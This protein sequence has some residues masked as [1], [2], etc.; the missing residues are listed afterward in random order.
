MAYIFSQ[1]V[2]ADHAKID[3]KMNDVEVQKICYLKKTCKPEWKRLA[4]ISTK[5]EPVI[6]Y[7]IILISKFVEPL[8]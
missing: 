2:K 8:K 3:I 5:N 1:N 7:S 4:N 6:K